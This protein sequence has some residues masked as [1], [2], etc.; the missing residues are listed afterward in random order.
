MVY[1]RLKLSTICQ[2]T[3]LLIISSTHV[4]N[5]AHTNLLEEQSKLK[6]KCD[7]N[8]TL[9]KV[10]TTPPQKDGL[11]RLTEKYK[12]MIRTWGRV[13]C[14]LGLHRKHK[15]HQ[16]RNQSLPSFWADDNLVYLSFQVPPV[17]CEHKDLCVSYK[18]FIS[19][20]CHGFLQG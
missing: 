12:L 13:Q 6:T 5:K 7:Y 4:H 17:L 16:V 2:K 18:F 3:F 20:T 10:H 14:H 19:S 15:C 11:Y 1:F 9:Y 8:K